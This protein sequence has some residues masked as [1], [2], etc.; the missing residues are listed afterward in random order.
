MNRTINN[1][2]VTVK[3][4]EFYKWCYPTFIRGKNLKKV[5]NKRTVKWGK[6]FYVGPAH[7]P[8]YKES[9]I[10]MR[11]TRRF[12]RGK[13]QEECRERWHWAR[14]SRSRHSISFG[15]FVPRVLRHIPVFLISTVRRLISNKRFLARNKV[16]GRQQSFVVRDIQ[17][18][19]IFYL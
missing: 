5:E 14:S 3:A 17:R 12:W 10:G 13:C 9:C 6:G 16:S 18:N 4:A 7:E 15:G 11:G 1:N 2:F 8:Q 19:S